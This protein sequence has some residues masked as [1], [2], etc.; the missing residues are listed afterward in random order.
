M[1]SVRQEEF[2]L[3]LSL[4]EKA[5]SCLKGSPRWMTFLNLCERIRIESVF[6][7]L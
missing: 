6:L 5:N 3:A 2:V 1:L 4:S 7:L